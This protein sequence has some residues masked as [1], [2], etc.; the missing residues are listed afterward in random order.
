MKYRIDWIQE[1]T[2]DKIVL[3]VGA[4][5]G[6]IHSAIKKV[7]KEIV[8]IDIK[9]APGIIKADAETYVFEPKHYFDV[10][11]LG[12]CLEHIHNPGKVFECSKL[13]LR[14]NGCLIITTPNLRYPWV[15]LKDKLSK[16]HFH[17]YTPNLIKQTLI[18]Y[19]FKPEKPVFFKM[20]GNTS[21][22]GK[23]FSSFLLFRPMFSLHFG[24]KAAL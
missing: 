20:E 10:I 12:N 18:D 21:A 2:K 15:C 22:G 13:N 19:G 7:A 3:D 23:L 14:P 4:A 6:A 11:F 8:G 5:T 9:E 24:I 16:Y 17:G 1:N